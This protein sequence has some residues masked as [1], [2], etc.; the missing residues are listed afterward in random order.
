[1]SGHDKC[2]TTI[3]IG[4]LEEWKKRLV[5]FWVGLFLL[6]FVRKDSVESIMYQYLQPMDRTFTEELGK[7]VRAFQSLD[8]ELRT[9]VEKDCKRELTLSWADALSNRSIKDPEGRLYLQG[10][11]A[12]VLMRV[13]DSGFKAAELHSKGN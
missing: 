1:M 5:C 13:K 8:I 4:T 2:L 12:K 3:V 10:M 7:D 11:T 9:Q 6:G